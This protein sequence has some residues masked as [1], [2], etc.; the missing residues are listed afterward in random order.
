MCG[1][2]HL[3]T[4]RVPGWEM[5]QQVLNSKEL[6]PLQSFCMNFVNASKTADGRVEHADVLGELRPR[7]IDNERKS[8]QHEHKEEHIDDRIAVLCKIYIKLR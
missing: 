6:E 8:D 7:M 2:R 1:S 3:S 5:V 4:I